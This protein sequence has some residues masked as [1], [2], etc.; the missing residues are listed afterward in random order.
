[1]IPLGPVTLF[2]GHD[3]VVIEYPV[4]EPPNTEADEKCD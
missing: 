1:M 3:G 2:L 4:Q